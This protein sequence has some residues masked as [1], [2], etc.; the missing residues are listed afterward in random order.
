MA[1][2]V[3]VSYSQKDKPVADAVVA[4][5]EQG[6]IRCWVAPRDIQPGSSWGESIVDA[7]GKSRFM[8]I[9]L[10]R[11]S[12]KSRQVVREVE[13]AV[14]SN[15][16][17]IPF[18]I[19]KNNPTGAMSYFLSTEHWLDALTPPLEEHITRLTET[20]RMFQTGEKMPGTGKGSGRT[21]SVRGASKKKKRILAAAALLLLCA[22][23]A[24][25]IA[26]SKM[27]PSAN[28]LDLQGSYAVSGSATGLFLGEE[29]DTL[30]LTGSSEGALALSVENPAEPT[31]RWKISGQDAVDLAVSQGKMYLIRGEYSMTLATLD[32][33]SGGGSFPDP[34]TDLV[35]PNMASLYGVTVAEEYLHL[36]GHNY[37]GIY[38]ISSPGTPVELF[39]WTPAQ[40][41]GNPCSVQVRGAIAYVGAGWD[42]LYIFDVSNPRA[43]VQLSHFD[44]PDW[45]IGMDVQEDTAVLSLGD[46]GLMTVDVSDPA[47]PL[48]LGVVELPGFTGMLSVSDVWAY[49]RYWDEENL[50]HPAGVVSVDL[51]DPENPVAGPVF[52]GLTGGTDIIARGDA[53]YVSDETQGLL[54][55]KGN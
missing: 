46:S 7:I 13:R 35:P 43:P 16:I 51:S 23:I 33:V 11:N 26:L 42:G 34:G 6:G 24:G 40:N 5:L 55:L 12:N 10:S 3:F 2:D 49:V 4:G 21:A 52:D 37:W 27:G 41:S 8:V 39:S 18:R 36:A 15:V 38:D 47:R 32:A 17:I 1:H 9:I 45:I 14:S 48:A 22:A 20:I 19:D 31:L 44:T 28:V 30:Y 29:E 25:G 53:V 54:V 50:E